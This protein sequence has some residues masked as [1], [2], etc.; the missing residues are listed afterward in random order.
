[1]QGQGQGQVVGSG[2]VCGT[3]TRPGTGTAP[4]S[5]AGAGMGAGVGVGYGN[6]YMGQHGHGYGRRYE[7]ER[8]CE[9]ENRGHLGADAVSASSSIPLKETPTAGHNPTTS[10]REDPRPPSAFPRP[11][12]QAGVV[13]SAWQEENVARA[14]P[15]DQAD[16]GV[17][18][19]APR[20]ERGKDPG[21]Q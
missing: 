7:R 19:D 2:L 1:V 18:K 6:G 3:G 16:K 5:M 13:S 11:A 14:L 10:A 9:P 15:L 21:M 8:E 20:E 12:F 4:F 17:S